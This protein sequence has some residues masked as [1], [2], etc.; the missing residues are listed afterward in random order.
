MNLVALMKGTY[1][2]LSTDEKLLRLLHYIPVNQNDN[3]LSLDKPNITD[4]EID[5]KFEI[6]DNVLYHS[7]KK[8]KLDLKSK[9]S[10]INFYLDERK[11]ERVYSAGARKLVNNP[12]ISRQELV[13]DVHTN[14]EIDR[15][16]MRLYQIVERV[17][18]LLNGK[19]YGQFVGL[20]FSNGYTIKNTPD[21]F[22]GYRLVY[23]VIASQQSGC[24]Y[25]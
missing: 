25:D 13:V 18:K 23:Y 1:K 10:R 6:I 9:F 12:L 20:K 22:I 16:D 14:I 21:G 7:D 11:P 24:S 3:P 5:S 19:N 2:Q 17:E 4:M 15:I 8:F